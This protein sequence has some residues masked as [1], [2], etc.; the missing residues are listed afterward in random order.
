V[1]AHF[2]AQAAV[3]TNVMDALAAQGISRAL[4][5]TGRT[6]ATQTG[7]VHR[8]MAAAGG[9]ISGVFHDTIQHVHRESVLRA[10]EQARALGADGIVDRV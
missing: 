2:A 9:R 8:V 3:N 6:L 5:I 10:T 7:L 4:L 1:T